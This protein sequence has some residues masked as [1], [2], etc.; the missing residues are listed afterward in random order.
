MSNPAV[1]LT[2]LEV[3]DELA[4]P[5]P[6]LDDAVRLQV[7]ASIIEA[8]HLKDVDTLAIVSGDGQ[9]TSAGSDFADPLVVKATNSF[10]RV[11]VDAPV[12]FEVVEGAASFNGAA[13]VEVATNADGVASA[14][15]LTAGPDAGT[16]TVKATSGDAT[17][18][19]TLQV[20]AAGDPALAVSIEA[21]DSAQRGATFDVTVTIT[22]TG[23]AAANDINANVWIPRNATVEL[24]AG[25]SKRGSRITLDPG[26]LAPGDSVTYT[27]VVTKT[28]YVLPIKAYASTTTSTGELIE[29]EAQH[30]VRR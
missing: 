30:T 25:A 24:P 19:F 23:Q 28:S 7:I 26:S 29:S 21:P 1:P 22:N 13:T 18:T 20:I 14:P 12:K 9:S 3:M 4:Q 16:V 17:A 11:V 5:Q 2:L 15:T 27:F 6:G 10:D 8:L